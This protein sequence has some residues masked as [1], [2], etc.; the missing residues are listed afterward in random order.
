MPVSVPTPEQLKAIAQQM[1]LSLT[2][3]DIASF[4]TLMQPSVDAYNI[5]DR[6]PDHLPQ[7]TY[8]RPGIV[9]PR[10]RTPI[11]PGITKP[12]LQGR[13]KAS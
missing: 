3:G 1:G 12:A 8:P 7:V 5:V 4:L 2:E 11:M 9:P 10:R 6:L 13:A